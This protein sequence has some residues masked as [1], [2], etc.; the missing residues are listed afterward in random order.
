MRRLRM[1]ASV[2]SSLP[3][4]TNNIS[5]APSANRPSR[6]GARDAG[7]EGR[8]RLLLVLDRRDQGQDSGGAQP[9]RAAP[10]DTQDLGAHRHGAGLVGLEQAQGGRAAAGQQVCDRDAVAWAVLDPP[11]VPGAERARGEDPQVRA[12]D[13]ALVKRLIQRGSSIRFWNVIQGVRGMVTSASTS[14]SPAPALA[15][16][17]AADL[18]AVRAQV[19]AEQARRDVA[20]ELAAH[21]AASS[22]A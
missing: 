9:P 12:G 7:E 10:Q 11:R 21:Q 18:D 3:S 6:I 1:A 14:P 8:D 20:A 17:G 15:D 5:Q 22:S 13:P 4:S 19:L 16:L 2:L